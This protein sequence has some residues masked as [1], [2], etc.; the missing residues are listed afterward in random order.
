VPPEGV[1]YEAAQSTLVV[2][3]EDVCGMTEGNYMFLMDA[4]TEDGTEIES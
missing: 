1:G 4:I 2:L 3:V